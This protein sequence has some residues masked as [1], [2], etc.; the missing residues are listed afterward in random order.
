VLTLG[1][2]LLVAVTSATMVG[3]FRLI[4]FAIAGALFLTSSVG[5]A[6]VVQLLAERM[7]SLGKAQDCPDIIRT[8]R[9][10]A[11]YCLA[12]LFPVGGWFIVAPLAFFATIGAMFG[13]LPAERPV[14][15]PLDISRTDIV[16]AARS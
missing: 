5:C 15:A 10:T 7:D 3:G 13:K 11:V 16:E 2:A 4:P 1:I 6:A 14:F 12:G 8:V 9:A